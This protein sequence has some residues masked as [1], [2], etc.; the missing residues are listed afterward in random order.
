MI[1][2][3][4]PKLQIG[5]AYHLMNQLKKVRNQVSAGR[6]LVLLWIG[7]SSQGERAAMMAWRMMSKDKHEIDW[8]L[9]WI[10][11]VPAI[12]LPLL[13]IISTLPRHENIHGVRSTLLLAAIS[14]LTL[15]NIF[16]SVFGASIVT[17]RYFQFSSNQESGNL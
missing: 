10:R 14:F 12:C 9:F 4:L 5:F 16:W 8:S 7:S 2:D 15:A 6:R 17:R 1:V 13:V 3:L 11:E